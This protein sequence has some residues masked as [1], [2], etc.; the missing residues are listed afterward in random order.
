[1]F[2]HS[3]QKLA[4]EKLYILYV[5]KEVGFSLSKNTITDIFMENELSNFFALQQYLYELA[6]DAFVLTCED[7]SP[8]LFSITQRGKEVLEF[9]EKKLPFSKR[10][11]I[12]AY[13]RKKKEY[14]LKKK[15]V[16]STYEKL[17]DGNFQVR[18]S[19]SNNENPIFSVQMTVASSAMARRI[20]NHWDNSPTE[21]YRNCMNTFVGPSKE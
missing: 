9:F 16:Q 14:L 5:L 4:E 15:E 6:E 3:T 7:N 8:I 13:L 1:M 11:R 18:L 10:E 19:M 20:C 2:E 21:I 12:D 17:P